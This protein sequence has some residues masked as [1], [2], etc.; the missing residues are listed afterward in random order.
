MRVGDFMARRWLDSRNIS[1]LGINGRLVVPADQFLAAY[2]RQR[3]RPVK[4][5][6]RRR[7]DA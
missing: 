2:K 4:R 3:G 1:I 7:R 6:R 5:V